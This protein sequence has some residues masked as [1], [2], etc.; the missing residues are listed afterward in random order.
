MLLIL[1]H[2]LLP[3]KLDCGGLIIYGVVHCSSPGIR[4]YLCFTKLSSHYHHCSAGYCMLLLR[5][6]SDLQEDY[7]IIHQKNEKL[8]C[9]YC[10]SWEVLKQSSWIENWYQCNKFSLLKNRPWLD[11]YFF[12]ELCCMGPEEKIRWHGVRFC[13]W[14]AGQTIADHILRRGNRSSTKKIL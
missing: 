4:T 1:R 11:R 6:L 8:L 14:N 2:I 13:N 5:V 9:I 7:T 10:V 3:L 12:A